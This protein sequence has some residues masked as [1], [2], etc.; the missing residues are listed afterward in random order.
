MLKLMD[1]TPKKT[2]YVPPLWFML[3]F[4]ATDKFS[5]SEWF[6]WDNWTPCQVAAYCGALPA[7]SWLL[8]H[9]DLGE[10][11]TV[12]SSYDAAANAEL[13]KQGWRDEASS[14][15]ISSSRKERDR[16]TD[17]DSTRS[18]NDDT[19]WKGICA[20]SIAAD[21]GFLDAAREVLRWFPPR[22]MKLLRVNP[23]EVRDGAGRTPLLSAVLNDHQ[24]IADILLG[25]GARTDIRDNT[26][27]TVLSYATCSDSTKMLNLLVQGQPHLD[28]PTVRTSL[29]HLACKAVLGEDSRVL[30]RILATDRLEFDTDIEK[31]IRR[32]W[33]SPEVR[34]NEV[35]CPETLLDLAAYCGV[36]KAVVSVLIDKGA[37][38]ARQGKA[39]LAPLHYAVL[40]G[41]LEMV[42]LL[43][44]LGADLNMPTTGQ[45]VVT[46]LSN[47][48][49]LLQYL[50]KAGAP[51]P[52]HWDYVG[53]L[54][55]NIFQLPLSRNS[56][57]AGATFSHWIDNCFSVPSREA[58]HALPL[59]LATVAGEVDYLSTMLD[60]IRREQDE[61]PGFY[62]WSLLHCSAR[63]ESGVECLKLLQYEVDALARNKLGE[64]ALHLAVL[65][66]K[67]DAVSLLLEADPRS[68][69]STDCYGNT[70][71]H[72]A[73]FWHASPNPELVETLLRHGADSEIK[74]ASEETALHAALQMDECSTRDTLID[75]FR[76][77]RALRDAGKTS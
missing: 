10:V 22:L 20:L 25:H 53:D 39:G 67:V 54:I 21:R 31:D 69:N 66:G 3:Y 65:A 46:E 44:D 40:G 74:N 11:V 47:R 33:I 60:A 43:I 34:L 45:Q 16:D 30:Q 26:G 36:G 50:V 56:D 64:T 5:S 59:V 48:L 61:L 17:T 73:T 63:F 12:L 2:R 58:L 14:D 37:D 1:I 4:T 49:S 71:L 24:E 27:G 68:I 52:S 9:R 62:S 77:S 57:P 35:P 42:R 38:L 8:Q 41:H 6:K 13:R 15:T 72:F 18:Q 55:P 51:Y 23:L 7:L 76:R 70:A 32:H 19:D 29:R 75:L 28:P